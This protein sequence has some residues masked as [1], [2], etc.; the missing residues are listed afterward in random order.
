MIGKSVDGDRDGV[1][2][3]HADSDDSGLPLDDEDGVADGL[4][5]DATR[6]VL[7]VPVTNTTGGPALL[8]AWIDLDASGTFDADERAS[9]TVPKGATSATLTWAKRGRSHTGYG[10]TQVIAVR[11]PRPASSGTTGPVDTFLRLRIMPATARTVSPVGYVIGGEVEDHP[12]RLI[13]ET[14]TTTALTSTD[15][16]PTTGPATAAYTK[17]GLGL[18]A[19]GGSILGLAWLLG[20]RRA[21]EQARRESAVNKR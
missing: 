1:A 20:R 3:A 15:T 11:G 17:L 10:S 8:A 7:R 12:V 16:L 2:S 14:V 6:P 5:I 18:V 9:V 13:T 21:G 4:R 19:F